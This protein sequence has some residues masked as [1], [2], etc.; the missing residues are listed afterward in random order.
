MNQNDEFCGGCGSKLIVS[1]ATKPNSCPVCLNGMSPEQTHC[2][3]CGS[4]R[5]LF[6]AE[7]L[8][9]VSTASSKSSRWPGII[10]ASIGLAVIIFAFL[11]YS[12]TGEALRLDNNPAVG[13]QHIMSV[14]IGIVGL[15]IFIAGLVSLA[16][17]SNKS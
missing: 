15:I 2:L 13:L 10:I 6:R 17:S 7:G 11:N 4:N 5:N 3:K 16:K 12:T 9:Q 8:A 1:S 14:P